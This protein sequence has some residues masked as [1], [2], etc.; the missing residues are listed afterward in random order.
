[1]TSQPQ[2]VPPPGPDGPTADILA[3]LTAVL[4]DTLDVEPGRIDPRQP[5]QALGVDSIFAAEF[6]AA[7][8]ARFGTAVTAA[9]LYEHPAPAD[10][11]RHLAAAGVQGRTG[12][13]GTSGVPARSGADAVLAG[14]RDHLAATVHCDPAELDPEAGFPLLGLDSILAAEFVAAVNRAYGLTERPVT[15]Y[16]HPS[17]RA[18]AEYIAGAAPGVPEAAGS[19]TGA[20][21]APHAARSDLTRD[22]VNA[23]LDA[24]RDDMLTVDEAVTL[25]TPRPA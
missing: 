10:L 13:P 16:D 17:L 11:A 23:L 7:L 19:L 1:M 15:L 18:M 21:A 14:L 9:A 25:L 22:E 12:V 24:V 20:G 4:A 3:G 5:F 6:V 8:N 2:T